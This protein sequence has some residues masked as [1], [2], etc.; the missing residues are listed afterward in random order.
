MRKEVK[1]TVEYGVADNK[2]VFLTTEIGDGQIGSSVVLLTGANTLLK[3]G[4]VKNLKIGKGSE[5]RG[6][7][8][9]PGSR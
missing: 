6:K 2:N 3:I 8:R 9:L 7:G 1:F 4:E 5:L